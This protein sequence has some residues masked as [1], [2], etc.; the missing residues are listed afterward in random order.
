L[1]KQGYKGIISIKKKI[2]ESN[3]NAWKDIFIIPHDIKNYFSVEKSIINDETRKSTRSEKMPQIIG[4]ASGVSAENT[5]EAFSTSESRIPSCETVENKKE[6]KE[7]RRQYMGVA[8]TE[9]VVGISSTDRRGST[10]DFEGFGS[11]GTTPD[12]LNRENSQIKPEEDKENEKNKNEN[13][14]KTEGPED[15]G[16]GQTPN[17]DIAYHGQKQVIL[18]KQILWYKSDYFISKEYFGQFKARLNRYFVYE[19]KHYYELE[20]PQD[21]FTDKHFIRFLEEVTPITFQEFENMRER[22][23]EVKKEEKGK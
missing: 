3:F 2:K 6:E 17:Q 4:T 5:L 8:G 10:S 1:E 23:K 16:K 9:E 15:Q 13:I 18:E 22:S 14:G 19:L 20:A 7:T 12:T 21:I 11:A